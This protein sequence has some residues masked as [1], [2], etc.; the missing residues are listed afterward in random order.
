MVSL[1]ENGTS[2]NLPAH[3]IDAAVHAHQGTGPHVADQAI[4]LDGQVASAVHAHLALILG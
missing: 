4:V 1:M 3:E 2:R